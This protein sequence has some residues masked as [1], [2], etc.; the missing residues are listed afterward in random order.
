MSRARLTGTI[1]GYALWFGVLYV[2]FTW[3]T[4]PWSSVSTTS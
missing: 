2:L 3:L 1:A 4:F